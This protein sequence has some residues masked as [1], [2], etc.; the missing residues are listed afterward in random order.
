MNTKIAK[1]LINVVIDFVAMSLVSSETF[2]SYASSEFF[3]FTQFLKHCSNILNAVEFKLCTSMFGRCQHDLIQ[4]YG[5]IEKASLEQV[6]LIA[7]DYE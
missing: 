6:N 5:A 2:P 7:G 1:N 3:T 4:V